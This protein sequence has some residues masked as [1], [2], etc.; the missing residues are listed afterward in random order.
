MFKNFLTQVLSKT[1]KILSNKKFWATALVASFLLVTSQI[2]AVSAAVPQFNVFTGEQDFLKAGWQSGSQTIDFTDPLSAPTAKEGDLVKFR[3]YFHNATEGTLAVDTKVKVEIPTTFAKSLTATANLSAI[4]V[5]SVA[6]QVKIENLPANFRL[7]YVSGSTKLWTLSNSA[8]PD[9]FDQVTVLS[10]GVT[11]PDGVIIGNIQGCWEYRGFVTFQT[12]LVAQPVT[13]PVLTLDKRV[14]KT[15]ASAGENLTYTLSYGNTGNATA[16][17]AS[18]VD[19]LPAQVNFVSATPN[20]T[21]TSGSDLTWNL[22]DLTIAASGTITI[23]AQVKPDLAVGNYTLANS[24]TLS[25]SNAPSISAQVQTSVSVVQPGAPELRIKKYVSAD[26]QNW[27]NFS[28]NQQ[29][30][31]TTPGTQLTF[32]I[33][34]WNVGQSD[35]TAVRV[36]DDVTVGNTNYYINIS[37]FE[38]NYGTVS[39]TANNV[40]ATA[41][42]HSFNATVNPVG[43]PVG[44]TQIMN[45]AQIVS[46]EQDVNIG[47]ASSTKTIVTVGL[48]PQAVVV[49][50]KSAFNETQN[51]DATA[52]RAHPSDIIAYTLTL[53]NT[54]NAEAL[55]YPISDDIIDILEYA[56]VIFYGGGTVS[57]GVITYSSVNITPSQI[58]NKTF[59][60]Q[61]KNPLSD[62]PQDGF[63]FD[64]V[65][66]NF[67]GNSMVIYLERPPV[68]PAEIRFDKFVRDLTRGETSSVKENVANPGDILEYKLWF[69]NTGTGTALQVRLFDVLPA[70]TSLV[71]GS[72]FMFKDVQQIPLSNL[73]ADWVT[74]GDLGPGQEAYITFKVNTS[75]MLAHTAVLTNRA[76]FSALGLEA[77]MAQAS[78]TIEV[79]VIKGEPQPPQVYPPTAILP[80]AP[81]PKALPPTGPGFIATATMFV[82]SMGGFI[83]S[84]KRE[85]LVELPFT[86]FN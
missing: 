24:A 38:G 22:G 27:F 23:I 6:D 43:F 75:S 84:R 44:D 42:S 46:N 83:Y 35:A 79:P 59:K 86:A 41:I 2:A 66:Y 82:L 69:K 50:S 15:Q 19:N 68:L 11:S 28:E 21:N 1:K 36:S 60:I 51:V 13:N 29:I 74:I 67:F 57:N 70:S 39:A 31:Q 32:K 18:L 65:M 8:N 17:S 9:N 20:S 73:T 5:S 16:V 58:V 80:R 40:E 52:V 25:A 77:I 30:L 56:D 53:Q 45:V 85:K 72:I 48:P 63:H 7:D 10:D 14:D 61:V 62:N 76:Y 37:P 54:G 78:T 4:G 71:P 55:N 12:V 64:M 26:G 49:L 47:L 81:V 33:L 34:V 3:V